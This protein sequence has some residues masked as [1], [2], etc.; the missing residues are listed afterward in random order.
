MRPTN[1]TK[2]V[3]DLLNNIFLKFYFNNLIHWIEINENIFDIPEEDWKLY[4]KINIDNFNIKISYFN[5]YLNCLEDC[6]AKY[7]ND[8]IDQWKKYNLF[9]K[10]PIKRRKILN[11]YLKYIYYF[12]NFM[13]IYNFKKV[14]ISFY[15]FRSFYDYFFMKTFFLNPP[16]FRNTTS[17]FYSKF[18]ILNYENIKIN[19]K[20]FFKE[21]YPIFN[22]YIFVDLCFLFRPR[23]LFLI[24]N[25]YNKTFLFH[26]AGIDSGHEGRKKQPIQVKCL[27][28]ILW[29]L[30]FR[31]H[32][33]KINIKFLNFKNKAI[34][35]LTMLIHLKYIKRFKNKTVKF[36]KFVFEL[37]QTF[38]FLKGKKLAVRKRFVVRKR[39]INYWTFDNYLKDLKKK[40]KNDF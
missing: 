7:L 21:Y 26:T 19:F 40:K 5:L 39:S 24:L 34:F 10:F 4:S 28:N 25:F 12:N 17:L 9:L 35:F 23:N 32:F 27:S 36:S 20:N 6:F 31:E 16:K 14:L 13:F 30:L 11:S 22:L 15:Q 37:K 8:N 38:G 3:G 29:H 1:Y 2:T 18:H 33:S